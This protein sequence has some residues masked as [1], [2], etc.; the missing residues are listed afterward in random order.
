M[1]TRGV[2]PSAKANG[3]PVPSCGAG[4]PDWTTTS[5]VTFGWQIG[6][7]QTVG[8]SSVL[9]LFTWT[10]SGSGVGAAVSATRSNA[11]TMRLEGESGPAQRIYDN[12]LRM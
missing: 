10:T 8:S 5:A 3:I 6:A 7:A 4:R 9:M 1:Y 2:P 11:L 12:R